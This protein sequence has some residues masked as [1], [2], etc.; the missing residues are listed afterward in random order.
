M[1]MTNVLSFCSILWVVQQVESVN[2]VV[3][4]VYAFTDESVCGSGNVPRIIKTRQEELSGSWHRWMRTFDSA[5]KYSI[6][7]PIT[8]TIGEH[9]SSDQLVDLE[10]TGLYARPNMDQMVMAF[11]A[12][13]EI[14]ISQLGTR[15]HLTVMQ[16]DSHTLLD[17]ELYFVD[18]QAVL[19]IRFERA[20]NHEMNDYRARAYLGPVR[21]QLNAYRLGIFQLQGD[22]CKAVQYAVVAITR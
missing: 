11:Y 6:G 17:T 19:R 4:D 12:E 7:R 21:G 10:F 14:P 3:R 20:I 13:I 2:S 8:T 15:S 22:G 16:S 5:F 1:K 9:S 18:Y